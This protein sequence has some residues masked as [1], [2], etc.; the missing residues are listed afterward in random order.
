MNRSERK[1]GRCRGLAL[2]LPAALLTIAGPGM[3]HQPAGAEGAPEGITRATI[4]D[5]GAIRTM[6]AMVVDAPRPALMI[7]YHGEDTL[8]VYDSDNQPF[9]RFSQNGVKAHTRSS[10]W[11]TLPQSRSHD[12]NE[13]RPWVT[14]SG[15]GNFGWVDPRLSP[16]GGG[17]PGDM[18]RWRIPV[19]QGDQ[20]IS[21]ITGKLA[22]QPITAPPE[23]T[24]H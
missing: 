19:R 21:A 3:A 6:S 13:G 16:A 9:L 22:W 10:Q 4:T 18:A 11:Q 17:H 14:V 15:S 24:G 7:R 8:T 23:A 5:Q 20:P 1:D 2:L 12:V